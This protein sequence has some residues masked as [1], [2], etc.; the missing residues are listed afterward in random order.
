MI[1]YIFY[2]GLLITY[3]FA[4]YAC[5]DLIYPS[6]LS[7]KTLDSYNV[8]AVVEIEKITPLADKSWYAAPFKFTGKI[9]KPIKGHYKSGDLI[10]GE[11]SGKNP[12]AACPMSLTEKK[13]YLL[14]FHGSRNPVTLPRYGSFY[15]EVGGN[16]Y[17]QYI[18]DLE[19]L[20]NKKINTK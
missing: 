11:T 12:G 10:F 16:Q 14:F 8:V 18:S 9:V 15:K 17:N 3:S 7:Q 5:K 4:S 1:K 6:N 20:M 2:I 13:S 19:S